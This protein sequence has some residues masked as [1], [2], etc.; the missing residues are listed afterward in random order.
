MI[1]SYVAGRGARRELKEAAKV[2]RRAIEAH[3]KTLAKWERASGD[4]KSAVELKP[5]DQQARD[6]ADIV[7]RNIARLIDS[8]RDLQQAAMAMMDKNQQ[9][10][11]KLKQLRGMIPAPDMPPGAGGDDEEDDEFPFG[12]QPGQQEGPTKEGNESSMSREEASW[13]LD[14]FK[15]DGERRLPMGEGDQ[16]AKPRDRSRPTW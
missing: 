3:G 1:R 11:E 10:G 2:V 7:D 14:G 5:A 6:N 16:E 9:L 8:L 15:L 4:F 13:I 12:P